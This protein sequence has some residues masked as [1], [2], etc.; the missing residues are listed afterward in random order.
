MFTLEEIAHLFHVKVHTV[1]IWLSRQKLVDAR[2]LPVRGKLKL[3]LTP[4]ELAKLLDLKAP[5]ISSNHRKA[6]SYRYI[7]ERNRRAGRASALAKLAKLEADRI[8]EKKED[9]N[10]K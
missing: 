9:D 3:A 5:F 7:C 6:K 1:R 4:A 8:A 10:G 2:L